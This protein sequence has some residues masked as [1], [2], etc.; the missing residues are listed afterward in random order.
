[1]TRLKW[2]WIRWLWS[3]AN[4][5]K[6]TAQKGLPGQ[7]P[8]G[9]L[10]GVPSL[11]AWAKIRFWDKRSYHWRFVT[12]F[13]AARHEPQGR[14]VREDL[15]VD[16]L[17]RRREDLARMACLT[18]GKYTRN[19]GQKQGPHNS[20]CRTITVAQ[21]PQGDLS[22]CIWHMEGLVRWALCRWK[23]ILQDA[24][25]GCYADARPCSLLCN[26]LTVI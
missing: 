2:S 19:C 20:I 15:S 22:L 26:D 12:I 11:W 14:K 4:R 18:K 8:A 24:Q 5:P 1:M 13:S 10:C 17:P 3:G 23:G 6:W 21:G 7:I 16:T 25:Q 9:L